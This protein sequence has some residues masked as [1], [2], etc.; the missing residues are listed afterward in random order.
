MCYLLAL[1]H[2]VD[3][4]QPNRAGAT[5]THAV[6]CLRELTF[7]A[8]RERAADVAERR[9]NGEPLSED[10]GDDVV[11]AGAAPDMSVLVGGVYERVER[12]NALVSQARETPLAPDGTLVPAISKD[13][14]LSIGCGFAGCLV[15]LSAVVPRALVKHRAVCPF[16]PVV[17]PRHCGQHVAS[18]LLS[19]HVSSECIV[20]NRRILRF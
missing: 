5:E 14:Q 17:C 2:S 9:R 1:P 19:E 18:Y 20:T 6:E 16:R 8:W 15:D 4:L 13:G 11:G 3:R 12:S 10:D 7:H